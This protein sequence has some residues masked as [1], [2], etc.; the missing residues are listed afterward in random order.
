MK[1]IGSV[2]DDESDL[3]EAI[4]K[5]H[6]PNGIELDPMYNKGNFYKRIP[7]PKYRF[8]IN[9]IVSDCEKADATYLP[10]KDNTIQ[11]MILDPPFMF[12]I[13]G[14]S[15]QYYSSKTHG[16]YKNFDELALQY[17]AIL[18]EANR[19]LKPK[20]TLIFKCQDYT[21]SRTTMTHVHVFNWAMK[22]AF[23]PKDIAILHKPHGKIAN[24]NLT[25]RHLRK[26]HTYFWVFTV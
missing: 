24:H 16:I 18:L 8:D 23:Y 15:D 1:H 9:P 25:Q 6:A 2:F 26:H 7:K 20:G 11:C 19:V 22:L 5:L 3:L 17:H 12:G 4:L 13:H 10:I 14:K 21:D